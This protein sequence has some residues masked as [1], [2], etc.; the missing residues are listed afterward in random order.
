MENLTWQRVTE[1]I[2]PLRKELCDRGGSITDA[3]SEI[4]ENLVEALEAFS[5]I[6]E[7]WYSAWQEWCAT[8]VLVSLPPAAN[9]LGY[10]HVDSSMRV[11]EALSI[12]YPD[13]L[14][15]SWNIQDVFTWL[16]ELSADTSQTT[17]DIV[18]S[19]F[20]GVTKG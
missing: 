16:K 20:L 1:S 15:P 13:G 2:A 12:I 14:P 6:E 7:A 10:T 19:D 11:A 3:H 17:V 8:G 18:R 5:P 9:R 4:T